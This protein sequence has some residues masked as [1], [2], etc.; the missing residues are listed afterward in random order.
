MIGSWLGLAL[1]VPA[2][3]IIGGCARSF[4]R[5][6]APF[7]SKLNILVVGIGYGFVLALVVHFL[8]GKESVIAAVLLFLWGL[9]SALYL[10][11]KPDPID[12]AKKSQQVGIVAAGAYVLVSLGF[13][14]L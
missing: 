2:L 3:V 14:V 13:L 1:G 4:V 8:V 9:L 12:W 5:H 6:N 11:Y 7:Y 10:G